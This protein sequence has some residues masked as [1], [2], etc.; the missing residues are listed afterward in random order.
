[1]F[2]P[3]IRKAAIAQLNA[4]ED[5]VVYAAAIALQQVDNIDDIIENAE[6]DD[7]EASTLIDFIR[8]NMDSIFL[9]AGYLYVRTKSISGFMN[10]II[11]IEAD[12]SEPVIQQRTRNLRQEKILA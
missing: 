11:N 9:P 2:S 3:K 7:W 5:S 1:M 10:G 8:G 4:P 12:A 6:E